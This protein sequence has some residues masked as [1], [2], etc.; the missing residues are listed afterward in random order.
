[1]IYRFPVDSGRVN[2]LIQVSN[3]DYRKGGLWQTPVLGTI[4]GIFHYKLQ[5]Y[6]LEYLVFG[7]ILFMGLYHFGLYIFKFKNRLNVIF[8]LICLI[9]VLRAASVGQY[10]LTDIFPNMP[11]ELLIKVEYVSFFLISLFTVVFIRGLFQ[12][13]FPRLAEKIIG[14]FFFTAIVL[15]LIL[16]AKFSSYLITPVQIVSMVSAAFCFY[17]LFKAIMDKNV[18]ALIFIVGFVVLVVALFNDLLF[19]NNILATGSY[20]AVGLCLYFFTHAMIFSVRRLTV[21][22]RLRLMCCSFTVSLFT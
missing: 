22:S 5:K 18:E 2:I 11:W 1:M 13:H 21:F 10:V 6:Q 3:Y 20:F 16:P 19:Y 8:G 14:G 15:T 17:V 4:E 7:T 12:D 9:T